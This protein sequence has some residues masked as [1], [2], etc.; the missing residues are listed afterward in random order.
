MENNDED[1]WFFFF[2]FFFV[3]IIC[4]WLSGSRLYLLGS[5]I[6]LRN[7]YER[8][9]VA[10]LVKSEQVTDLKRIGLDLQ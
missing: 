9:D 6:V 5:A 2:W 1:Y 8:A 4:D 3:R 7:L 10:I